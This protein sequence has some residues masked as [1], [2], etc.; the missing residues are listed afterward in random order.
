MHLSTLLQFALTALIGSIINLFFME[1]REHLQTDF[2][3][4]NIIMTLTSD[5]PSLASHYENNTLTIEV[6][7]IIFFT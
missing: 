1:L 3:M 4:L 5:P 6:Q 2:G 7:N